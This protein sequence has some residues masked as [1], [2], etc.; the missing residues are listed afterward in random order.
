MIPITKPAARALSDAMC[1]PSSP[2][3]SRMVGATTRAAK[4]PYTTV[5]MPAR[6][7]ISGLAALLNPTSCVFRKVN[8]CQKSDG[9]RYQQRNNRNE[10][11][12][13]KDRHRAE[14]S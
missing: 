14:S 8:C 4:K 1:S 11:R 7:S 2:P 13:G 10:Q 9:N 12:A 6:I 5:G 3:V